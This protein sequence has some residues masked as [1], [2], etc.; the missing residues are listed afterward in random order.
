MISIIAAIGNNNV[1]GSKNSLPWHLPADFKH[2]K[3]IT[4]GKPCIMGQKTF[5][6]IGKPLPGR[7]NIVLSLAKNLKLNGCTVASS[8]EDALKA[9][10]EAKE[11]M[12]CGGASV[13]RQFLPLADRLYITL[14]HG[15][16]EGDAFFPEI[17]RADWNE[18]ERKDF[19]ADAKNSCSYSFIIF[20][21]KK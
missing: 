13:Y 21:R 4:L 18:A 15:D 10:G 19:G 20:D 12:I 11:V 6:S 2:F 14:V 9:A 7:T 3:E 8:I 5:E 17:E 1:I 16:F